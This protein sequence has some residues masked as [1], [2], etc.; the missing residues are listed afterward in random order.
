MALEWKVE[1][2]D[3]PGYQTEDIAAIESAT[4]K[5]FSELLAER[6]LSAFQS[7]NKFVDVTVSMLAQ[8]RSGDNLIIDTALNVY[9]IG[10]SGL[11]DLSDLLRFVTNKNTTGSDDFPALDSLIGMGVKVGMVSFAN[12]KESEVLVGGVRS[13]NF[14]SPGRGK[15][16]TESERT[17]IVV[18]SVLSVAL[19]ALSIILIW[20]AGGWLALRKQV[21]VLMHREEKI[22]RMNTDRA[23]KQNPT[24]DTEDE[25]DSPRNHDEENATQF[26]NPSGILGVN[27][28][29]GKSAASTFKGLGVKMTPARKKRLD[30]M[31]SS[32]GLDSPS[33]EYSDSGRM[34]IGIQSMRKLLALRNDNDSI[35][36][37]PSGM[38]RLDYDE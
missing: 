6:S 29:Y 30:D 9:H 10:D 20:V 7:P 37:D 34:P 12:S 15:R 24:Q 1:G 19:F 14:H 8:V 31:D 5:Y 25:I 4:A 18:T 28:Y 27:P 17:L 23:L 11:A 3:F 38:K 16:Y 36:G 22:S 2:S 33:S 26:T 35:L 21:E 13:F 32:A